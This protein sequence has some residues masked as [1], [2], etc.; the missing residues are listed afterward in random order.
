MDNDEKEKLVN[1]WITAEK[2]GSNSSDYKA[3]WWAI[4]TLIKLPDENPELTWE[5]ILRIFHKLEEVK[6]TRLLEIL[7]AGPIEDLLCSYGQNIIDRV[8]IEAKNNITFK[9][10]IKGVWLTSADTPVQ[11]RFYKIAGVKPFNE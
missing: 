3:N 6:D 5:V 2:G 4:E 8:E 11:Q 9:E 1:A 10:C 7:A